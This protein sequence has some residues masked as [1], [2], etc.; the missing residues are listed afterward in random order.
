MGQFDILC[1]RLG[2]IHARTPL[3]AVAKQSCC[4]HLWLGWNMF[5]MDR[6]SLSKTDCVLICCAWQ[7][8][9]QQLATNCLANAK[10]NARGEHKQTNF[11][12]GVG[13]EYSLLRYVFAVFFVSIFWILTPKSI[14]KWSPSRQKIDE[15]WCRSPSWKS[16]RTCTQH[17]WFCF[18][19]S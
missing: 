19:F 18:Y 10:K 15:K 13:V 12:L 3:H 11:S 14:P 1:I 6:A 2:D 5:S 9:Q 4:P 16:V 17:L 8:Q 7:Q